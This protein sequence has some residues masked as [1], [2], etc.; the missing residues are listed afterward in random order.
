MEDQ[1]Y[2]NRSFNPWYHLFFLFAF[3]IV[4]LLVFNFF[5]FLFAL[6]AVNFDFNELLS[7]MENP[8]SGPETR[9]PLLIVQGITGIGTF[10]LVPLIYRKYVDRN[11]SLTLE[12]NRKEK[13]ENFLIVILFTFAIMPLTAQLMEWNLS[14]KFPEF[15]SEFEKQLRETHDFVEESTKHLVS[16]NGVFELIL[17]I[18]VIA[19]IPAIGEEFLFR[20]FFQKYLIKGFN[21]VH[22]GIFVTAFLFGLFHLQIFVILP[23][24]LLGLV[25]GYF[26]HYSKNLLIPMMAHFV[27]NAFMVTMLYMYN[28]GIIEFNIEDESQISAVLVLSSLIFSAALFFYLRSKYS[29]N[30]KME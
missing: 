27:N 28:Q 3:V 17:G 24:I 11:E 1:N 5:G 16:L 10:I 19:V 13:I 23:R 6:V 22:L 20:G 9:I 7:I 25:F 12:V 8:L 2:S 14:L 15:L 30:T 18:V 29:A 4:G 26:Y 21:N